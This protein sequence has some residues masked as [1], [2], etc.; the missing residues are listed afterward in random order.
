M[1]TGGHIEPISIAGDKLAWKKAQNKAKNN[2]TSEV[3]NKI[4]PKRKPSCTVCVW[5][6]ANVASRITSLHQTN[7]EQITMKIPKSNIVVP[8]WN[9]CINIAAPMAV[10]KHEIAE[11]RGHGLGSTK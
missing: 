8:F 9:E 5:Q 1:L 11:T 3:I 7:I 6:P 4:I 2:I 10:T